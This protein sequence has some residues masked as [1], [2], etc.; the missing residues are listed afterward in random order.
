MEQKDAIV[1]LAALA[2]VTRLDA[3]RLLVNHE[4]DGLAAGDLARLLSVP[5]NTLSNHLSIM[6]RADLVSS[7]RLGR[8]M[9][10]RAI[11]PSFHPVVLFLLQECCLGHPEACGLIETLAPPLPPPKKKRSHART[12]I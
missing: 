1:A 11:L 9:V 7:K 8:S 3:F 5:Q 4:P 2:Q 10:F 12:R 6:A